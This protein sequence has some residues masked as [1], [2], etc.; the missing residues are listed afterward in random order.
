[1]LGLLLA[2]FNAALVEL[3]L[4]AFWRWR[5][6]SIRAVGGPP[7]R[8]KP[9]IGVGISICLGVRGGVFC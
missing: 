8:R 9:G 2:F 7:G 4:R 1:L 5:V 6:R 3:K